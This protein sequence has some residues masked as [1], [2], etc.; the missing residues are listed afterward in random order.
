[1]RL[2]YKQLAKQIAANKIFGILLLLLTILTSLSYFFVKFSIDGNIKNLNSLPDLA[3]N[4]E[5]YKVAL[6]SNTALANTFILSMISLTAFVFIM[7]FYR[8]LRA[9]KK[10]IGC[11]K[12]LGFKD[13]CLRWFF[14][15]FTATVS[16]TGA[17][18]GLAAGYFLSDILIKA[19]TR[20][21]AVTG[22]IKGLNAFSLFIGIIVTTIVF[23]LVTFLCY[24]FVRNKETGVLLAG[25][26]TVNRFSKTLMIANR[27]VGM[28]PVKNQFPLR[29][30][31]RKPVAVLMILVAVMVFNVCMLLGYSLNISSKDVFESQTIGHEYEYEARF[32]SYQM[33]PVSADSLEFL[34][35]SA[36]L[37]VRGKEVMQTIVGIYNLNAVYQLQDDKGNN[38]RT[39][40]TGFIYINPGIEEIYGVKV[41]DTL[42]VNISGTIYSFTV[43]G[44]AE[45][46][47][48]AS[49]YVNAIELAKILGVSSGAYNGIF[50]MNEVKYC[51]ELI[52]NDQR[53]ENLNRNAVSNKISAIINQV[54]GCVVGAIL[55][56][57]A[58]L[59]NFQDNTRD[60]LILS[61]LG[62]RIKAIRKLLIDVY[63]PI[64]WGF[65]VLTIVPSIL[66]AQAIQ[67]SLSI[68]TGD[69]MPFGTNIIFIILVF[70]LLNII[71]WIVKTVTN[72]GVKRVIKKEE[73][74]EYINI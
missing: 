49:V 16:I 47:K 33:E 4:Q 44:I 34:D 27:L 54:I 60:I 59:I 29:I 9:N 74:S 70:A 73:I 17:L 15:I 31:L 52:T 61:M 1:M 55:I 22:L 36:S 24:Y 6:E 43:G 8:F 23:C 42:K 5:R 35:C 50:S 32:L 66:T 68:S 72:L 26:Q 13:A 10:Q 30:A 46:A 63:L 51:D 45:N 39:P 37:S 40:Y 65:F 21:Y 48:A 12:S 2:A 53:I 57:I 3:E 18:L 67:K 58:L 41:G 56:L 71:Y 25:N 64:V 14:V 19:N 20:T 38:L 62:Y 28:I 7:F 69:Y 11:L